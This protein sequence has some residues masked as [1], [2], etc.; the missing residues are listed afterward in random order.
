MEQT[1]SQRIKI[2]MNHGLI[3]GLILV[4]MEVL[5]WLTNING[6]GIYQLIHWAVL[7][8]AIYKSMKIW[9]DEYN[10]G[11]IRYGQALGFGIRIMFFASIIFG[12]YNM[13]FFSLIDPAALEKSLVAVEEG[14]YSMGFNDDQIEQLM[15]MAEEL[16]TPVWQVIST[17]I[18]TTFLGLI[19]SL[20]VSIFIK[21]EGDPFRSTMDRIQDE[22]GQDNL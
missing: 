6:S 5:V 1:K 15:I 20:I 12:F 2:Y 18:G 7:I 10:G 14:Y 22:P 16:Q 17:V 9:R 13:I 3:I 21:K 11:F 19:L 4:T 8:G